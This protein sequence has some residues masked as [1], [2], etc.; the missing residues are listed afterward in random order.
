MRESISHNFICIG[1]PMNSKIIQYALERGATHIGLPWYEADD[2]DAAVAVMADRQN[3]ATY[4]AWFAKASRLEDDLRRAGL[5]PVRAVVRAAAF[6]SYCRAA[7]LN[8]DSEGR[9]SFA[10]LIARKAVSGGEH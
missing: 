2:F 10:N 7:N 1:A 5:I 6:V 8:I 3:F 4:S 9:N